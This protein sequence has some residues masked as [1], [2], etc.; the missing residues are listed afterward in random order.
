MGYNLQRGSGLNFGKGRCDFL[1]NF[2]PKGKPPNYY[3]KTHRGLEYVTPPP[4]TSFQSEDNKPIPSQ[5]TTS[6][7]WESDV[8]T[9]MLF[10]NLSINMTSISQ[11]E[12]G[13]TIETVD[14]ELWAQQLDCQWEKQFE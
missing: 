3:D 2:V 14:A 7:E 12:R 10:K 6:S 8:S 5:S 9:R 4:S 11:L 1:R 13:E